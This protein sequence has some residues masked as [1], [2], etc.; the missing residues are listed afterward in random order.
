MDRGRDKTL[1]TFGPTEPYP[2]RHL[3]E[4]NVSP[5]HEVRVPDGQGPPRPSY[6]RLTQSL[7]TC[8][9]CCW[10]PEREP[11]KPARHGPQPRHHTGQES[12]GEPLKTSREVLEP[13]VL[14]LH[15]EPRVS[16]GGAIG[17]ISNKTIQIAE[18]GWT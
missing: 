13:S 18:T 9:P 10:E 2:G 1:K 6:W 12:P 11:R 4:V 14:S 3:D 15:P 16:G 17:W 5:R 7:S 8:K